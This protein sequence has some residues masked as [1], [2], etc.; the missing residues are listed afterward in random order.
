MEK[1]LKQFFKFL[2]NDKTNHNVN[3]LIQYL[4][5]PLED[6]LLL[7]NASGMKINEKTKAYQALAK[8]ATII[9]TD[10]MSEVEFSG[11]LQRECETQGNVRIE[12][13][14]LNLFYKTIG[15]NLDLAKNE[16]DKIITYVGENGV[17]T[18]SIARKLLCKG[19]QND[20]YS[21]SNAI[22]DKDKTK[23]IQIYQELTRYEKDVTVLINL[24]TKSFKDILLVKI[25]DEEGLNQNR[26]ASKMHLNPN[27]V[28]YM[29]KNASNY[30]L[31][32]IE[33]NVSKL[34]TLDLKIKSGQIDKKVG[35]E[36]YLLGI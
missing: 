16:V 21:L 13:A 32:E 20:I 26:I 11:W 22:F 10:G 18:E 23:V 19:G 36:Q 3:L 7:I 33:S 29:L 35:F 28:Y 1:Q 14:A 24:I 31:K 6:S 2:E 30:T 27:R 25:L 17:I 12:P 9:N 34:A 15:I 8:K 4:E 5:H